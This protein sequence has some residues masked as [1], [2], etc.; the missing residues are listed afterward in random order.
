MGEGAMKRHQLEEIRARSLKNILSKLEHNLI[1]DADLVQEKHLHIRLLEWFNFPSCPLQQQVLALILRLSKHSS[2]AQIYVDIGGVEFL[3]QL[4]SNSESS[5]HKLIDEILDNF[6]HLPYTEQQQH[7]PQ[8]LY[9]QHAHTIGAVP[10]EFLQPTEFVTGQELQPVDV[11]QNIGKQPS[12]EPQLTGYFGQEMEDTK[13]NAYIRE[14]VPAA[15]ASCFKFCT[16][17]WI[18]LTPTDRHV[19]SSTDVSL[20]SKDVSL[21]ISACEFL[22]DVVFRDFPAEVFLQRPFIIKSL[23]SLLVVPANDFSDLS[24]HTIQTLKDLTSALETRIYY[25]QD[26]T[27]YTPKQDFALRSPPGSSSSSFLSHSLASSDSRPSVIG[28]SDTRQGGDGQDGDSSQ[29][30]SNTGM[31]EQIGDLIEQTD[32]DEVQSL[33]FLQ[34]TTPQFCIALLEKILPCL[35]TANEHFVLN[36][37]S[38]IHQ[39][40]ALLRESVSATTLWE[41]S[42]LPAREL[43]EK[44]HD[45]LEMIGDVM[46][47]HHHS[48]LSV[49]APTAKMAEHRMAYIGLAVF[50]VRLIETLVPVENIKDAL[51]EFTVGIIGLLSQDEPMSYSYPDI[52][53]FT[54]GLLQQLDPDGFNLLTHTQTICLS[55][56][57]TCT[58]LMEYKDLSDDKVLDLLNMA[59]DSLRSLCYHQNLEYKKTSPNPLA[60]QQ[61]LS[62]LLMI[63]AHPLAD[64]RQQAYKTILTIVK[65]AL[66]VEHVIEPTSTLSQS[67]IFLFDDKFLYQLMSFGCSDTD[68][69]VQQMAEEILLYLLQSQLLVP[70]SR[71]QQLLDS[72]VGVLPI[73]QGLGEPDTKLSKCIV[74]LLATDPQLDNGALPLLERFRG[75]LRCM[76]SPHA[77]IRM[78]GLGK[79]AWFLANEED[80]MRKLPLFSDLDVTN[81]TNILLVDPQRSLLDED[82]EPSVFTPESLKK[83]FEIFVSE[84]VEATVRHSAGEQL[85]IIMHDPS[86][87]GT[88]H[89]LFALDKILMMMKAGVQ[90]PES[91]T[92]NV[93]STVLP[94]IVKILRCLVQH[95]YTLRHK[96][97]HDT[98]MYYLILRCGLLHHRDTVARKEVSELFAFLLF[99]EVAQVKL[100]ENQDVEAPI[101]FSLPYFI[102]KRYNLP[103]RCLTHHSS[104]PYMIQMPPDP[105]PLMSG[106]LAEMLRIVW[107]VSWHGDISEALKSDTPSE[108]DQ[109]QYNKYLRLTPVDRVILSTSHM[110]SAI[111]Q[112]VYNIENATGHSMV[113]KA[114]LHFS[115]C[116]V[117]ST[118]HNITEVLQQIKWQEAIT[119]F[120]TVIPCSSADESLLGEILQMLI[121]LL[122][123]PYGK[124]T[125]FMK[126]AVTLLQNPKGALLGLLN[127]TETSSDDISEDV[128]KARR[129][130]NRHLLKFVQTFIG[131]Y[132]YS[133]INRRTFECVRGDLTQNLLTRI[134]RRDTTHFYNLA[135]LESTLLCL[136]HITA[137]PG[138]S[139]GSPESNSLSLS[140]QTLQNLSEVI[141]A[142][143]FGRGGMSMSYMG[144]GVTRCATICLR[145]LAYEMATQLQSKDWP[146]NWL[147]SRQA[148]ADS[149]GESGLHWL[150]PLWSYRDTEVRAAGVGIAAALTST[151]A[152]RIT[153]ATQCQHIPGGIWGTAFSL[154]LD[155]TECSIV[156][157]QAAL[158]LVNLTSQPMSSGSVETA[159]TVWQGPI[160]RNEE[161]QVSLVGLSALLALLHHSQFYHEMMVL[162]SN[163]Y[164][165]PAIHP[166]SVAGRS[167]QSSHHT[168]QGTLTT[169]GSVTPGG[170]SHMTD[171]STSTS[172]FSAMAEHLSQLSLRPDTMGQ[173]PNNN[174]EASTGTQLRQNSTQLRQNSTQLRQ[175]NTQAGP[176]TGQSQQD[177][178]QLRSGDGT[179]PRHNNVSQRADITPTGSLGGLQTAS[180]SNQTQSPSV[181]TNT[182]ASL[183]GDRSG[184]PS[185]SDISIRAEYQSIVTPCLVSAVCHLL[186]NIVAIAPQDTLLCINAENIHTAL[187]NLLDIGLIEAY[188]TELCNTLYKKQFLIT[189]QDLLRVHCDILDIIRKCLLQDDNIRTDLLQNNNGLKQIVRMLGVSY[190]DDPD[191][192]AICTRLWYTVFRLLASL[193]QSD[194][195]K[196]LPYITP[197]IVKYWSTVSGRVVRILQD[198]IQTETELWVAAQTFLALLLCEEGKLLKHQDGEKDPDTYYI[199][200]RLDDE[201]SKGTGDLFNSSSGTVLCQELIKAYDVVCRRSLEQHYIVKMAVMNALKMLLHRT[202]TA[203]AAALEAGLVET[204][205]SHLKHIHLQL[206]MDALELSKATQNKKKDNPLI[207][208]LILNFDLL[209]NFMFDYSE[210]KVAAYECSLAGIVHCIWAWCQIDTS[211]MDTTLALLST[212]TA[213]CTQAASSLAFTSPSQILERP[214]LQAQHSNN[215]LV[216]AL[217]K[218]LQRQSSLTHSK[219][220]LRA[221]FS[222]LANLTLS[223]ECRGILWKSNFLHEFA[224]FSPKKNKK[225]KQSRLLE[226][227]WLKL[228]VNLSFSTEGQNMILKIDDSVSLLLEFGTSS[229]TYNQAYATLILRNLCFHSANKPKLL[230]NDKLVPFFVELLEVSDGEVKK[231]VASALLAL[232]YNNQKAKGVLKNGHTQ[233]KIQDCYNH[234]VNLSEDAKQ[235]TWLRNSTRDLENLL[236]LLRT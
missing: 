98:T 40:A 201:S 170:T 72:I 20:K 55:M 48:N 202:R 156:R 186:G 44:F 122:N 86:L 195:Q 124:S 66:G 218:M 231:V 222:L 164:P 42:S 191:T 167:P 139:L 157:E 155:Q 149:V 147:F 7:I 99:D 131:K 102:T 108:D 182:P 153:M 212:F 134:S 175:N 50:L 192:E 203:K 9:Q 33:Q 15:T 87:H 141:S 97:A 189:F 32:V 127:R 92:V 116:L 219:Q 111:Q 118:H 196:A 67:I 14:T 89:K 114:V 224:G 62:I 158:L 235:T 179:E 234:L 74:G 140:L 39:V 214:L 11:P 227:L 168:S 204:V 19:L 169:T 160:V 159:A 104:S 34:W 115:S 126:W 174:L 165:Q 96:W 176:E 177:S 70:A 68:Y 120:I 185:S 228:L 223:Q 22:S 13:P 45:I 137:R 82:T 162:L 211:L 51:P 123:V 37:L 205:C 136:M 130:L 83:V 57:N 17:P 178:V 188:R 144:C 100:W 128:L 233:R 3:S 5:L 193:L 194:G 78:E 207:A 84:S 63:T 49:M 154:L 230:S 172:Q 225:N 52:R 28:H 4:R 161:T 41:D 112:C 145:H 65:E 229:S 109:I 43:R 94:C 132:P 27:L 181:G 221:G 138:W 71:W 198:D 152:G 8:C 59:E 77:R 81:L 217:I 6:F 206:N 209:R 23:L 75:T 60:I 135:S 24:E 69:K 30:T 47:L 90:K 21:V 105:D 125:D 2:A 101:T 79:I 80:S 1:C 197:V 38:L 129:Q 119:R 56:T 25:Y 117:V 12:P 91:N 163:Y 93:Y 88:F 187:I 220:L 199:L 121:L 36:G 151:E 190:Q 103:F 61:S 29:N 216:H 236:L 73:L 31:P 180:R 46:Y 148:T 215:S 16:F 10:A 133:L 113:A 143:H 95:D 232:A 35:K 226:T 200:D 110:P 208:E 106:S 54:S 213:K 64:V 171:T 146:R 76:Y 184:T 166:V 150:I 85:A 53:I 173:N 18:P 183:P 26:P 58:F 142:F 107:N 210:V